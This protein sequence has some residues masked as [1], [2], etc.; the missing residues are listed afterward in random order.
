MRP[1]GPC[2]GGGPLWAP[3][4]LRDVEEEVEFCHP[5]FLRPQ[6]VSLQHKEKGAEQRELGLGLRDVAKTAR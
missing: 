6:A 1:V 5:L 2:S 4:G 3:P